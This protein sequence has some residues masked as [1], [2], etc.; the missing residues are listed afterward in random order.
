MQDVENEPDNEAV[1]PAAPQTRGTIR[2]QEPGVTR[3]RPATVA[4]ARARGFDELYLT[5]WIE[6]H[7]ARRFYERNGVVEVGRYAFV[8][9]DQVDDDRIL[10]LTL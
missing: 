5:V 7:R 3:P 6:N 1:D 4:E 8:V 10:R 2:S 9:G